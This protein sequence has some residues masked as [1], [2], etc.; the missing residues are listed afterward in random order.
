MDKFE[1]IEKHPDTLTKEEKDFLISEIEGEI[2]T[3]KGKNHFAN[4]LILFQVFILILIVK[5]F[6]G[7]IASYISL[8]AVIALIAKWS[9]KSYTTIISKDVENLLT[10]LKK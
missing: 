9:Y 1:L 3:T 10:E 7:S 4:F 6:D 2:E 8:F 5:F